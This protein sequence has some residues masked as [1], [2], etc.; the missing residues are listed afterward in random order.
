MPIIVETIAGEDLDLG[1]SS[2][3]KTHAG[4]G[5]LNATKISLSTFSLAGAAGLAPT[6]T[7]D[8]GSVAV[9]GSTSTSISVPG[10]AIGDK[11]LPSLSTMLA[12]DIMI[13]AH[14]S[15]SDTVRVVLFN[16]SSAAIDL[17]SGTLS[18]LVFHHR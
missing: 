13:S 3:T 16:P 7:W 15:A 5:T 14:V 4:G 9:G 6:S 12:N 18:L 11:V 17:A 10:A 8:P 2:T 1:V